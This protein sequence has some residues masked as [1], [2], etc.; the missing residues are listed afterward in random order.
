MKYLGIF[1]TVVG[2]ITTLKGLG[3]LPPMI[4][5]AIMTFLG[6]MTYNKQTALPAA[7]EKQTLP[8][9]TTTTPKSK[10]QLTDEMIIRLAKRL[11]NRLSVDDLTTQTS[12][13]REQ[14]K[15]R[16]EKLHQQGICQINLDNVEESGKIY[17]NF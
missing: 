11:D 7:Q 9:S 10:F 3:H 8:S 15:E 14:A 16:L 1:L 13:T 12:L 2:I 4:A 6:I 5:G 17:Y